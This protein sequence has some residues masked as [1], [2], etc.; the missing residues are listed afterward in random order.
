MT[1]DHC[2]RDHTLAAEGERHIRWALAEMPVLRTLHE[3]YSR[4]RPLAAIRA[5]ACL[6]VTTETANLLRVLQ[7]GGAM[8]RLCASNPLSTQ[9]DVAAA[10]VA[11][12]GIPVFA[13]RGES[14]SEY[15]AHIDAALDHRPQLT[16]DDGADLV[17]RLH[18][19]RSELLADVIGG[20]LRKAAAISDFI[21]TATGD[22]NIVAAEHLAVA[23]NGCVLANAGP[24]NVEIDI[25]ALEALAASKSRPRTNVEEYV[26][27]DGRRL[28]LLA[29]GRLVNLAAAEGHPSAVMDMSFGQLAAVRLAT[30]AALRD[31]PVLAE[32][33]T[34]VRRS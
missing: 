2:I 7:A 4:E 30:D 11:H 21:V 6:H 23:K 17:T 34:Q 10:L 22:K 32:N 28:C 33:A 9:D 16:L 19:A 18:S 24:F 20:M 3:R 5:S 14:T 27:R 25:H 12:S 8:V 1:T 29:E 13:M 31:V 26:L 15:Y